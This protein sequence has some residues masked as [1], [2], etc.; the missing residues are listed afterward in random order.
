MLKIDIWTNIFEIRARVR[1][2][3]RKNRFEAF[4]LLTAMT[5]L[6]LLSLLLLRSRYG[7]CLI[8]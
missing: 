6:I 4:D 8:P 3:L 1:G 5:A 2:M 7:L